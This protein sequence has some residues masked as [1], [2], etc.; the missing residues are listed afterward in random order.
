MPAG[1]GTHG[2]TMV[3]LKLHDAVLPL[4]SVAVHVTAVLPTGNALPD[5]GV[6]VTVTPGQLSVAE[7]V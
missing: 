5:G 1:G 2:Q 4:P 6:H 3:T 7:T